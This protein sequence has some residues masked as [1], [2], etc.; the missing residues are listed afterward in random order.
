M[1]YAAK[2]FAVR[3][4]G[5]CRFCRA[6]GFAR[7]PARAAS[8]G[9]LTL[10]MSGMAQQNGYISCQTRAAPSTL[11]VPA[12]QPM[13]TLPITGFADEVS[14]NLATQIAAF[15]RFGL[16]GIDVRGVEGVNV[17]NLDD[18][19]IDSLKA[20]AKE[21]GLVIQCVCSPVNKVLFSNEARDGELKKLHAAVRVALKL[22]VKRIRIFTPEVPRGED[23]AYWPGV[24]A[25]MAEQI[26]VAEKAGLVLI[27]END[28][29]FYGAYPDNAK[30]LFSELACPSFKA[31]FDFANT[32]LIGFRPMRDWF[33]WILPH[34]D[35]LHIKDAIETEGKVVPAGQGD[36]E[37][38]ETLRFLILDKGWTGPLTLEPHLSAAG[39]FGGFSGE[40][41]FEE[42]VKALRS[43]LAQVEGAA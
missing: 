43:V 20:Q 30:R 7:P 12:R 28:A 9:V 34:L 41:L 16:N 36:G 23:D 21:A 22:D 5:M 38:L 40:Q 18:A 3:N 10:K 24:K 32:V 2:P 11:R 13:S 8:F 15:K 33:P 19:T 25:W 37:L 27:H 26:E 14:P 35:T 6:I 17:L 1:G 29:R 4:L 31:V 39:A 42:A